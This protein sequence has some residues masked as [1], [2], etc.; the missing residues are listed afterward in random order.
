[1]IISPRKL[2][3][4]VKFVASHSKGSSF[5]VILGVV[6]A[7]GFYIGLLTLSEITMLYDSLI[8]NTMLLT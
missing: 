3:Q 7:C 2:L 8:I 6:L 5:A 1:M 4:A